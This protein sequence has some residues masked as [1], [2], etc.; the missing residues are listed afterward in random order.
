M[1]FVSKIFSGLTGGGEMPM[2]SPAPVAPTIDNSAAELDARQRDERLR[3]AS[4]GR[5]STVLTG[6][7]GLSTEPDSASA[8]K[9]LL[10]A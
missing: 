2:P 10:G 1:G 8:S 3:R 5:A 6:G 9:K 4:A 7:M